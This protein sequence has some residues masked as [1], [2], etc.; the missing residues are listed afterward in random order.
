M[1]KTALAGSLAM[2]S[3]PLQAA[4]AVSSLPAITVTAP[5]P[6]ALEQ[7][8]TSAASLRELLDDAPSMSF[9]SA[10][11]ISGLPVLRGLADDRV[12]LRVDGMEITS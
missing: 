1:R 6:D 11:G 10:G 3:L 9:Q 7:T 2:L 12:R 4:D 5:A 8:R